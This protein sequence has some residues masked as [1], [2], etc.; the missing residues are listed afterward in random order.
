MFYSD[1]QDFLNF[2]EKKGELKRIKT[3]V[4]SDLEITEIADRIVKK[5]GPAILFENIK[6]SKY[7]LLTNMFGTKKRMCMSLGVEK[8][9]EISDKIEKLFPK[10]MPKSLWEKISFFVQLKKMADIQPHIVKDAVSQE[11]VE[12]NGSLEAL[13]I[14]KCW[15]DDAGKFITFP[16]VFT[17]DPETGHQ[18]I[19]MY[20]MQVYD[21]KTTGMHWHEHHDGA[22]IYRK[23]K[24]NKEKMPVAVALGA[25]PSIIYSAT[26]PLPPG[27][28]ELMFAGFLR[29][30]AVPVIKAKT[31]DLL[32]PANA[33]FILEGY[34]DPDELR[35]EGPFGDHTGY[36][37]L[38]NDFPVFHLNCITR[39]K[40]PI[41][42]ATIVGRPPMEDCFMGW[43]TERI[44]LP[45]LRLSLPEIRDFS[46]PFEGVFHNCAIV[47]IKKEFPGH[48]R[49]VINALWGMGQMMFSKM[50]VVVDEDVNV[51]DYSEV[52]WKVFNNVDPAR[53]TFIQMG[54]LDV[55][56][57]SSSIQSYGS[58]MGIDATKKMKEEGHSRPWPDEIKMTE[59]VRQLVNSRWKEYGLY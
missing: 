23:Y 43:A 48:A 21:G 33:E 29:G 16:L 58:K 31:V 13:P 38:A 6:G 59:E 26:A 53:D 7:P 15:P 27:V 22:R 18:N 37:S 28:D 17:K 12:E 52:V 47:S 2:L 1:M 44:F 50:I 49:K 4:D 51:Q 5:G 14:L 10:D 40:D 9:D 3:E 24:K 30:K 56:D 8:I 54:P 36:Y 39:R 32:V 45:L 11:V 25:D 20:R 42:P 34:V 35:R 46:L 55:L 41:Y 19:G 57:H